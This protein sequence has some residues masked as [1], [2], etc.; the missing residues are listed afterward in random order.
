MAPAARVGTVFPTL[1]SFFFLR[2]GVIIP[3]HSHLREAPAEGRSNPRPPQRPAGTGG[4]AGRDPLPPPTP[5]SR[6]LPAAGTQTGSLRPRREFFYWLVPLRSRPATKA[7]LVR[8]RLP[9][10][11]G[12]PRRAALAGRTVRPSGAARPPGGRAGQLRAGRVAERPEE[13]PEDGR[14]RPRCQSRAGAAR[15]AERSAGHCRCAGAAGTV[16]SPHW[17]GTRNRSNRP[18]A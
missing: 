14:R 11:T 1:F 15:T 16:M 7:L 6:C 9:P 2:G 13:P 18:A 10:L 4:S 17:V 5:A 3:Q 12:W 8:F